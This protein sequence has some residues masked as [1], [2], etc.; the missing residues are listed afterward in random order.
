M[1]VLLMGNPNVG[2]SV[3]FSRLTG[4][5]VTS[6]NYPGT[7][8]EYTV[9]KMKWQGREHQLIDVPGTYT[10]EP[11]NRAEEVALDMIAR[12]DLVINVVDAT[13]LERNLNLTLQLLENDLPVIVALNL[14]D[15]AAHKGIKID[16]GRLEEL[17]GVPVVPTVAMTGQGLKELIDR[18][19]EAC[20]SCREMMKSEERWTEVGMMVS[21]V[22]IINHR[23]HTILEKLEDWSVQPFPGLPIGA[24]ILYLTFKFIR[25]LGE[26]MINNLTDPLFAR[27]YQPFLLRISDLLGGSGLLHDFLIGTLFA[28]EVD[29]EQ[30]FGLLSSGIYIPLGAVLPYIIAFYLA[31]SFLEDSGYLPRMA[32]LVDNVMHSLGLHGFAIIPFV[33]GF[34]CNVPAAL[35]IRSLESKRQKFIASTLVSI[36]VPCAAQT[37]VI[38][39]LVGQYGEK[40]LAYL[41]AILFTIGFITGMLM[42]WLVPGYSMPLLLEI[43]PYRLPGLKVLGQKVWLRVK[44]FLKEALP[45]VLLGV[46]LVNLLYHLGFVGLLG[47]TLGPFFQQVFGLPREAVSALLVGF[48]RK[49]VA[50]GMLAP[51]QLTVKQIVTASAV[52]TIYFPCMATFMVLYRELGG[53]AMARASGIMLLVAIFVGSFINFSFGQEGFTIRGWLLTGFLFLLISGIS[54]IKKEGDP[55]PPGK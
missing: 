39:G 2:K 22:Q 20:I 25:L 51:L 3:V 13:N 30:S 32:V 54:L 5:S 18:L 21:Q 15:E 19:P 31:L 44:G 34:G 48:L 46:L 1:K 40:Y 53:R 47:K 33:L 7:T 43:P 36:A 26:G 38:M 52:L 29:F 28:G 35:S 24:L 42:N 4:T 45:Y 6:S 12:G 37:A 10:L 8:V 50:V 49:D 16:A 55:L 17:L 41:F 9:G 14:W 27:V 23:H 11:T